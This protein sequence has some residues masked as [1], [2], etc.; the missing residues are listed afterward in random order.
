MTTTLRLGT[1]RSP[2]AMAQSGQVAAA[3]EQHH[4]GLRVE[5]VPIIT[6]GDRLKGDLSSLGGK[7]LFT[8]ELE[9][10]LL[11]G[12]LDFAVHSLKD[13]PV[14]LP[15]GLEVVAYP[16]RADPRDVLV[17][18]VATS[19]DNLPMHSVVLTGSTRRRAQL[20]DQRPDLHIEPLRGNVDTRLRKWRESDAAAVVL[21]AAGLHRLGLDDVPAHPIDPNLLVPA[22]G[23]GTLAIEARSGSPA[24]ALCAALD[25]PATARAATA[26]RHI[27]SMFGADCTMPLGAWA[28]EVDGGQ[29][30][31]IAELT[32]PGGEV[33]VRGEATGE[34]P[35]EVSMDC[36][37][38]MDLGETMLVLAWMGGA[39]PRL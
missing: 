3:L 32:A 9:E 29:L 11:G 18:K 36:I 22:P 24:A 14:A 19:L 10:G 5:L 8:A 6:Q 26:E 2:L 20:L 37:D 15:D 33:S 16:R 34:D 1:R 35:I 7:G 25:D 38:S 39:R 31:V 17:S 13:L 27:V 21:A 28:E 23:Q 30:R 12:E 4:E